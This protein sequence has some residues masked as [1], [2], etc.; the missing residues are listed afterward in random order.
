MTH[1]LENQFSLYLGCLKSEQLNHPFL[2]DLRDY[3]SYCVSFHVQFQK[4]DIDDVTQECFIKIIKQDLTVIKNIKGF[5]AT[6]ARNCTYDYFKSHKH[7]TSHVELNKIEQE[8]TLPEHLSRE[9]IEVLY[10]LKEIIDAMNNKCKT[11]LDMQQYKTISDSEISKHLELAINQI[12][13]NRLRCLSKLKQYLEKNKQS[14]LED[15]KSLL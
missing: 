7:E 14:L 13:Q 11:L 1:N 9:N 6:V 5:V 12:P 10:L 2:D 15:L 4:D 3:I 8:Q